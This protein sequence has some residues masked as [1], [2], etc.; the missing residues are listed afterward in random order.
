MT[1]TRYKEWASEP[2]VLSG[3]EDGSQSIGYSTDMIN[4]GPKNL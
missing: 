4:D 1:S 2:L 3:Y